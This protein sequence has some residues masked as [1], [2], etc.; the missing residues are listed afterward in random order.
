MDKI[1]NYSKS[2]E[3]Q[4]DRR[5]YTFCSVKM[6]VYLMDQAFDFLNSV[7]NGYTIPTT[8][9]IY[10]SQSKLYA[11]AMNGILSSLA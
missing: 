10:M 2:G 4:F 3:P 5:D 7:L 6:R 11:N 1:D 8:P 9:L